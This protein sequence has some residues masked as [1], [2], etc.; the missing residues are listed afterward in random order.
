MCFECGI[1][2]HDKVHRPTLTVQPGLAL[3]SNVEAMEEVR[4]NTG[5]IHPTSNVGTTLS[6]FIDF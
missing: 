6:G 3:Q 5:D 1:Y 2:G 4:G